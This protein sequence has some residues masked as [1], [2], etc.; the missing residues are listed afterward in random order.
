MQF[1]RFNSLAISLILR[2]WCPSPIIINFIFLLFLSISAAPTIVKRSWH[3]PWFPEYK[4]GNQGRMH[5]FDTLLSAANYL[6]NDD[7]ILFLLGSLI[8][9]F[10]DFEPFLRCNIELYGTMKS[11]KL[12]SAHVFGL[13]IR[14][15]IRMSTKS[16]SE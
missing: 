16:F 2:F 4:T 13:R 6:K 8:I 12:L 5:D 7:Q 9:F 15:T 1:L 14:S 10:L 3:L 11:Q